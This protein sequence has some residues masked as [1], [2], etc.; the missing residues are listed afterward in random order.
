[1][2]IELVD[3]LRCVEPH[4]DTWLVAS[5][6]RMDGRHIVDG[7]LGCPVCRREY[8]VRDGVAWFAELAQGTER[9][10]PIVSTGDADRVTRAAALLGLSD[11]G[12]IVVLG[13]HWV[14]CAERLTELGLAHLV[15]LN[16]APL[17]DTAQEVSGLC[18]SERLPF[19]AGSVRAAAIGDGLAHPRLMASVA[20]VLRPA[21]R[22]V[23]PAN[24]QLPDGLVELARDRDDW[25]AERTASAS[26]PVALRIH[27]R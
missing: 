11:G 24:T 18:V 3:S 2:F 1:M 4:E 26:A 7:I 5:V 16:A 15:V 8:P 14:D 22:L 9:L 12:G 27:R 23:G 21:G 19:A 6:S 25:V 20:A 13:G 17:P 10:T